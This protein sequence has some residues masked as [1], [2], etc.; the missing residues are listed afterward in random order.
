MNKQLMSLDFGFLGPAESDS[1]DEE[2]YTG[3]RPST[4]TEPPR[5]ESHSASS[6]KYHKLASPTRRKLYEVGGQHWQLQ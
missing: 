3:V 5:V 1:S 6:F 2:M 4:D